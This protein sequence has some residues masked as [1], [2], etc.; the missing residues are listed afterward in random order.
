[1]K[2]LTG[3]FDLSNI[4]IWT[5]AN[6][7]QNSADTGYN[8][9]LFFARAEMA[10]DFG[11]GYKMAIIQ[12]LKWNNNDGVGTAGSQQSLQFII[13]DTTPIIL[14]AVQAFTGGIPVFP[15]GLDYRPETSDLCVWG[16]VN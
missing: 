4:A 9:N 2:D 16:H 13:P 8:Q 6:I 5:N 11:N 3:S 1:Y 14:K 10:V 12:N 15:V 7:D